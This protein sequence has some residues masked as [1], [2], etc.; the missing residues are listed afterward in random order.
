[1]KTKVELDES[2]WVV[3]RCF[4]R[5]TEDRVR[6]AHTNPIFVDFPD[7][8]IR[9]RKAEVSYLIKRMQEE[10]ERNRAVLTGASLDEYREAERFFKAVQK[11]AR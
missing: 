2:A 6:F 5:H 3:V 1:M 4:E 8:P 7:S 11:T 10:I 9:P